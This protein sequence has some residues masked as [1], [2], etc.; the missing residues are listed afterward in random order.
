MKFMFLQTVVSENIENPSHSNARQIVKWIFSF[1]QELSLK[2]QR[3]RVPVLFFV[4]HVRCRQILGTVV[5]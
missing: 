4:V 5:P 2:R 3:S 1:K